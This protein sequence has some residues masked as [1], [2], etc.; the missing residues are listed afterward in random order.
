MRKANRDLQHLSHH[1]RREIGLATMLLCVVIVFLLCNLLPLV[2]NIFERFYG[3]IPMWLVQSGNLM[4]TIN[5]SVNF[6]IYVIFGRKFKRIFLRLFCSSSVFGQDRNSPEF[7]TNDESVVT[8]VTNIELRN[9][10]RRSHLHRS[11][12]ISRNNNVHLQSNGYPLNRQNTK[13]KS[14]P[15]SPGPCVYY[16]ARS[17]VRSPSQISRTS[18]AQNGWDKNHIVETSIQ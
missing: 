9:S 15:A 17:P 10:I 3:E 12:T 8:N 5:C 4:V 11:S 13:T 7:Q 16:P 14:R 6:I 18:S 2:T 1:Q